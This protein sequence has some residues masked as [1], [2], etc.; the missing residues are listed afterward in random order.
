[1]TASTRDATPRIRDVRC[2]ARRLRVELADGR[3][4][5]V[6][7]TW[8]PRLRDGTRAQRDRWRISAGGTGVHWP[9]LD[10]DLSA[11]GLLRGALA[12]G[13]RSRRR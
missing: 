10:E 2:A 12:P 8:F 13:S 7:L 6:P 1:V 9:D 5:I 4:L 11:E 3:S